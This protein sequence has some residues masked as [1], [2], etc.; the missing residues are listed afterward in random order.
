MT[1]SAASSTQR[2]QEHFPSPFGATT[3]PFQPS[4]P[5]PFHG[6]R[7][8]PVRGARRAGGA[9]GADH[10]GPDHQDD[11][12]GAACCSSMS[13]LNNAYCR[14]SARRSR[15][16]SWRRYARRKRSLIPQRH[17]PHAF[18]PRKIV[19]LANHQIV[20]LAQQLG[21]KWDMNAFCEKY[22]MPPL[23][24][25]DLLQARLLRRARITDTKCNTL[26]SCRCS[27]SSCSSTTAAQ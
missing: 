26:C 7:R 5:R 18:A 16:T 20:T 8:P 13:G 1:H 14:P 23:L 27:T 3:R 22:A 15:R 21:R 11:P 19:T 9:E 6:I 4:L 2:T 10:D 25:A 17:V 12:R 24:A